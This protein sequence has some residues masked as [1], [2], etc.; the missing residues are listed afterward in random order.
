MK[1]M[2]VFGTNIVSNNRISVAIGED[3]ESYNLNVADYTSNK[4]KVTI[5][6]KNNEAALEI[7][8]FKSQ[9]YH[10]SIRIENFD[11]QQLLSLSVN[12]NFELTTFKETQNGEE[13]IE[14][15]FYNEDI[16]VA[17]GQLLAPIITTY[18]NNV[19]AG[20]R[21]LL[22]IEGSNF[23]TIQGT[24]EVWFKNAYKETLNEW[25][26]PPS[27]DYKSW[28]S[29]KI[30]VYVPG[31]A[32]PNNGNSGI[33]GRYY[34]GSGKFKIHKFDGDSEEK[35]LIVNYAA[36]KDIIDKKSQPIFLNNENGSGSYTIAYSTAFKNKKDALNNK[37]TDAFQRALNTWCNETN[38]NFKIDPNA[39]PGGSYDVLVDIDNNS[40]T[41]IASTMTQ[42]Y[43]AAC[44]IDIENGS[45]NH[46]ETFLSDIM[47]TGN[48]IV[49]HELD[50]SLWDAGNIANDDYN[51]ERVSLHEL[52]HLHGIEH[53][54]NTGDLMF[55]S[56]SATTISSNDGVA[57]FYLQNMSGSHNCQSGAYEFAT[58]CITKTRNEIVNSNHL[59][60]FEGNDLV[61]KTEEEITLVSSEIFSIDGR[62]L[63]IFKVFNNRILA[64][65]DYLQSGV[66]LIAL[67]SDNQI[68]TSRFIITK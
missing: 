48:T 10:A 32:Y 67:K 19:T 59:I 61:L 28:S 39:Y 8:S 55:Y 29:T 46:P 40:G 26:K 45:P 66:Y 24:S 65:R 9:L 51:V 7:N 13:E 63:G 4:V 36:A 22:T 60:Y 12:E 68:F 11:L 43:N 62:S 38:L 52:G 35:D 47:M 25:I 53:S 54:N 3:F 5:E 33:R 6:K 44:S 49:F 30:E 27:G 14:C 1:E 37:F 56:P 58:E 31:F 64:L 41:A 57:S 42:I 23:G 18:N 50:A 20:T 34:A 17:I 21:T 16:T 15:N 2:N